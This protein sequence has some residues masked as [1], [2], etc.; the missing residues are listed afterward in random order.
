[1][2][3]EAGGDGDGG[4]DFLEGEDHAQSEAVLLPVL[5]WNPPSDRDTLSWGGNWRT[6]MCPK[7]DNHIH[8]LAWPNPP[9]RNTQSNTL[10]QLLY[11]PTHT[12]IQSERS[13]QSETQRHARPKARVWGGTALWRLFWQSLRLAQAG[14]LEPQLN[15]NGG[16][17]DPGN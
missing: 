7:M 12:E 6:Q 14:F 2:A 11:T 4:E 9:S 8:Q 17:P 13:T 3:T 5:P 15:R 16:H 10:T 1:M